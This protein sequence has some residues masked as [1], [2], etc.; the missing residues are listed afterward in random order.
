MHFSDKIPDTAAPLRY[1]LREDGVT[2]Y[3]LCSDAKGA[4][5]DRDAPPG[6]GIAVRLW[7]V[8]ERG[9]RD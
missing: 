6:E 4:T 3:S 5:F 1:A 2:V 8:A 7:D 9:K